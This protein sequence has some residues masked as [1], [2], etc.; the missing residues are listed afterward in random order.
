MVILAES[1]VS[2]LKDERIELPF[3]PTDN[4]VLRRIVG[5]LILIIRTREDLLCF[6]ETDSAL[7]VLP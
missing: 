5:S 2:D 3:C 6:L 7:G 1:I 4:A